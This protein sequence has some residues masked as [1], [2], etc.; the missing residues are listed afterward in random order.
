LGR[1]FYIGAVIIVLVVLANGIIK[2]VLQ[3]KSI[4]S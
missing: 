1:Q 4:E 2:Y 3:K